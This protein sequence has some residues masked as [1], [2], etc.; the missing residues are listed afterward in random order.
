VGKVSDGIFEYIPGTIRNFIGGW[1]EK[2]LRCA[3]REVLIK[4]IAQDV[5]TCPMSCCKLPP[6]ICKNMKTYI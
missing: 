2:L 5:P 1:S 6:T 3:G 4:S